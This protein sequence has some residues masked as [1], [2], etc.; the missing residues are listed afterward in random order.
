MTADKQQLLQI[1]FCLIGNKHPAVHKHLT[2]LKVVTK[3][4]LTCREL[5]FQHWVFSNSAAEFVGKSKVFV[6]NA[7]HSRDGTTALAVSTEQRSVELDPLALHNTLA[8]F[9]QLAHHDVIH[10]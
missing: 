3:A 7:D 6:C 9:V 10:G 5:R 4:P 1:Y 2:P 8:A